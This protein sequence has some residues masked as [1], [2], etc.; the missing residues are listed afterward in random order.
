M[1][2]SIAD[3][4]MERRA[5]L[6]NEAQE[7]ATRGVTEDRDLTVEEQTRFDQM[8]A[9]AG[10]L[11]QRAKAI[12]EG[13]DAANDLEESFRSSTGREPQRRNEK[14]QAFVEWARRAQ[15]GEGFTIASVAGAERR[16]AARVR[17]EERALSATGGVDQ[18]GVYGQLWEYAVASSQILQA[19][20][21]II[22]TTD[23]Q[24]L[25]FPVATAHSALQTA[26]AST[27]LTESDSTITTVDLSVAKFGFLTLVPTE[28]IQ[29]VTFD[30]EGYIS[31]NAGRALGVKV[32]AVAST[33]AKAGFTTAGSTGPTGTTLTL[34]AQ[35]TVGEGSDLLVDLFHS[36]LPEYRTQAAWTMAD[37]TAALVRKLK[38]STGEPV[39][40][41][42]LTAGD[43]DMILG[44]GVYVDPNLDSPGIS[45]KTIYFG[46]WSALKVRIAGGLR[47][48]RSNDYAFDADQVA[49]R[50]IVRSG[51]VA[52]DPNAVKY[53]V[54]SGT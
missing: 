43:P 27:S 20:V 48:E 37:P 23:G 3:N 19:G 17:G 5:A 25:P 49:F 47:F 7:V 16:A 22:N 1:S 18:D 35:D 29:D 39:W 40:Q 31:R 36:V 54:H 28:L 32:A 42:A 13:E 26:T 50:A 6:I 4:L 21:D 11:Y 14:S 44:K 34:G 41:A 15:I 53:F 2:A 24:T 38:T 33:A 46:D 51:S 10:K 45:K 9:E 12:K 52:V 30:L 8:V